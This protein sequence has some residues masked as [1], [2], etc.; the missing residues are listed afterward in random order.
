MGSQREEEDPRSQFNKELESL[1][2]WLSLSKLEQKLRRSIFEEVK[3][4]INTSLNNCKIEMIGSFYSGMYWWI[5]K[6]SYN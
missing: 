2:N 6:Q 3:S 1:L 4:I 5:V